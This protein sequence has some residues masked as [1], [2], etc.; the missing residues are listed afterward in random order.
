MKPQMRRPSIGPIHIRTGT[1]ADG[2]FSARIVFTLCLGTG[3]RQIFL[4]ICWWIHPK[5][6]IICLHLRRYRQ[7]GRIANTPSSFEHRF[8][9]D[10]D[11]L[12]RTRNHCLPTLFSPNNVLHYAYSKTMKHK[13]AKSISSRNLPLSFS[14]WWIWGY[15]GQW[16]WILGFSI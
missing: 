8:P 1:S 16:P 9:N 4:P 11:N 5:R 6:V 7:I 15:L 13:S 3:R 2:R 10:A 12:Q 14:F